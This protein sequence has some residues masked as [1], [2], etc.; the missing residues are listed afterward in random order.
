MNI[1]KHDFKQRISMRMNF[2]SNQ[3][4]TFQQSDVHFLFNYNN[5]F[6]L[7][8]LVLFLYPRHPAHLDQLLHSDA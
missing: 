6:T 8:F 7:I 5:L 3:I 1:G 4:E 2:S